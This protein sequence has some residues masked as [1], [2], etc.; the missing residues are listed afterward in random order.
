[1]SRT[2]SKLFVKLNLVIYAVNF[3]VLFVAMMLLLSTTKN[4]A[5]YMIPGIFLCAL[6]CLVYP[7][8]FNM[9]ASLFGWQQVTNPTPTQAFE[10]IKQIWNDAFTR[11]YSFLKDNGIVIATFCAVICWVVGIFCLFQQSRLN[12][13]VNSPMDWYKRKFLSTLIYTLFGGVYGVAMTVGSSAIVFAEE[14]LTGGMMVWAGYF[15]IC[16]IAILAGVVIILI[17][18][19]LSVQT[20]NCLSVEEQTAICEKQAKYMDKGQRRRQVRRM[21]DN[22]RTSAQLEKKNK[23]QN[24]KGN[25]KKGQADK[26]GTITTVTPTDK[27]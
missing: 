20:Y 24:K 3:A 22:A 18:R 15:L 4:L 23:S 2:L 1:M 6:V 12:K 13:I 16:G 11:D 21:G 26:A 8:F 25:N 14:K 10:H 19:F 17:E 9:V 5:F 27:N 7:D